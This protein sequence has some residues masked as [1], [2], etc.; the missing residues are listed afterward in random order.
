MPMTK[1]M[2]D[3][4]MNVKMT[5]NCEENGFRKKWTVCNKLQEFTWNDYR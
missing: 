3:R 5:M 1:I 2:K 4:R